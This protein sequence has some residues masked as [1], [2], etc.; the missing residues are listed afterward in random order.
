[1]VVT[2]I[3]P[4]TESRRGF[5]PIVDNIIK[6]QTYPFIEHIYLWGEGTIGAKRNKA[7]EQ[8]TG[9][10]IMHIDSDDYYSDDWV[11]KQA[12][13]LLTS[14][15]DICG[16]KNIYF[17]DKENKTAWQYRWGNSDAWVAGATLCY[18]KSFWQTHK[19]R[20]MQV[21]EDYYFLDNAR[22]KEGDYEN[23]FVAM[24]HGDNTAPHNKNN[25]WHVD[26][27]IKVSGLI[28]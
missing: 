27:Y 13:L 3:T 11:E 26:D 10:I 24:L 16:L 19:F 22:I 25:N 17:L 21:G 12:N 15:A 14:G 28:V 5:M 4:I 7:C 20:D 8:A 2:C 18:R 6:S 1:M 23:K 9:D